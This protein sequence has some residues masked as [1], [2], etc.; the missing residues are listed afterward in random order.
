MMDNGNTAVDTE[1][2]RNLS[3]QIID[4]VSKAV[5]GQYEFIEQ[6]VVV[7]LTG[8]HVLIE[9]VPG[10]AKTLAA[11]A[12]SKTVRA[13]FKRVQFT[14]DLMPADIMGTKVY[15][16]KSGSFYL[17]RGPLFTNIF[18]ADEVNRTPPKT[19][20]A[21]LESMEERSITIDGE[22]H[23][24]Q[25]PFMVVATQNPV[26][27]EGTYPLPEA[28]LDRFMMK[29]TVD[30]IPQKFEN[31]LLEKYNSGFSS[32]RLEDAD[33]H[34]VCGLEEIAR[35]REEIQKVEVNSG[36]INYITSIIRATRNSPA[37]MLGASPRASI[38]LL[39][40]SKTFAAIQGRS[41]VVPEDV[42]DL[43]LPVLRHRVI[44]KPEAGMDGLSNDDIIRN[45]LSKVEVPR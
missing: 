6:L 11:K 14:P 21:L 17:R 26:E 4:E 8:G 10:L 31:I 35:C 15:D 16:T 29:L 20:A 30:Y 1:F 40:A 22:T 42:K 2:T 9:G 7:L 12:I 45:I 23:S 43:A 38:S 39:L 13:D 18:L 27:Y 32:S 3:K 5:V 25:E 37:L 24:L 28:Q 33:I 34:A 44:L 36:I 41:F 19:Q